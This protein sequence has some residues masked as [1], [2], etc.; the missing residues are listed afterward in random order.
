VPTNYKKGDNLPILAGKLQSTRT[1][2]PFDFYD[3]NWCNNTAG[4]GYD[5]KPVSKNLRGVDLVH[6]PIDVS[7]SKSSAGYSTLSECERTA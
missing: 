7:A 6:T 1:E 4:G 3:L 2:L 5:L